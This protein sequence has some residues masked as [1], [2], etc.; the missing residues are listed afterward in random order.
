LIQSTPGN[1]WIGPANRKYFVLAQYSRHIRQGMTIIGSGDANT[2]AAYNAT[3]HTLVLV[4]ANYR[5]AQWITYNLSN[6]PSASG[7]VRRWT[8]VTGTGPSYQFDTNVAVN[9]RTFKAWFPTNSIQTFE[10]QNVD[11]KPR[12]TPSG[13][14]AE[15]GATDDV[16]NRRL[17]GSGIHAPQANPQTN[18]AL[19]LQP[20][21]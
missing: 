20:S 6:Y 21:L 5:T 4:T 16:P 1:G 19:A 9:Q 3:N 12:A 2:V 14:S 15:A 17:L 7:P 13:L 8:T 10:I 18:S 11:L